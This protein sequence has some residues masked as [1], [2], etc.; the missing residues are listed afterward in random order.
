MSPKLFEPVDDPTL[1]RLVVELYITLDVRQKQKRTALPW[2]EWV[3]M[4]HLKWY[5]RIWEA[6]VDR[7]RA[8]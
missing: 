6:L 3:L 2:I 7:E 1:Y 8:W 4:L 5:L